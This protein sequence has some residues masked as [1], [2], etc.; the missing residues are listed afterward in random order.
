MNLKFGVAAVVA[1]C[2]ALVLCGAAQA[3]ERVFVTISSRQDSAATQKLGDGFHLSLRDQMENAM[4]RA[5]KA[6][7]P[8]VSYLDDSAARKM[9]DVERQRQLLGGLGEDR[10]PAIAEAV[11]APQVAGIDIIVAGD[12]VSIGG[13]VVSRETAKAV[14]RAQ[15]TAP[16][17]RASEA[18]E[19]VAHKLVGSLGADAPKCGQWTGQMGVS[20]S[21][22]I[23]G[24]NPNGEPFTD[25]LTLEVS[26]SYQ[27]NAS[28]PKCHVSYSAS[29]K[30]VGA[31]TE[32]TAGGEARCN[33]AMSLVKGVARFRV[34]PCYIEGTYS[35]SV[36]GQ[37]G[38]DK[39][40]FSL[41]SW[42]A[43]CTAS[44]SARTLSGSK[45]LDQYT[46][47]TWSLSK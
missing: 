22:N 32:S 28:E 43:E 3:Q 11:G 21:R 19:Q 33:A 41:G 5:F 1:V 35:V 39:Q 20:A 2:G 24:K 29:M 7:Y 17:A 47:L 15:V 37:S 45:A 8:C 10:L 31:S 12:S 6:R 42:E 44:P 14:A 30:G 27:E 34:G 18:I 4:F 38:Q 46:T 23:S 40:V 13:V 16:V 9:L 25:T 26:C 36:A